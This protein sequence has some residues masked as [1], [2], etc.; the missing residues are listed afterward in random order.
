MAVARKLMTAGELERMS[1]DDYR[2]ELVGGELLRMSPVGGE[3]GLITVELVARLQA[4]VKQQGLGVVLV[5]V[6]YRLASDPDT[7]RAPDISFLATS[8][9]SPAG[10]PKGFIAGA[11]DLAVEVVSPE[12]TAAEIDA[13][14]QEYLVAGT[15]MVLVVQPR[16]RTVT[17]YRPDGAARVLRSSEV[18][19]GEDVLPGFTLRVDEIFM[20]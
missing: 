10:L 15:R 6:G 14:V 20:R 12:D 4:H 16:T 17:M 1:G 7:V 13:K 3:H 11:P 8:R 2:Y 19:G 5:E 9:I 18:M